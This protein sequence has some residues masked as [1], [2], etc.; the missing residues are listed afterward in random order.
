MV[1]AVGGAT[2]FPLAITLLFAEFPVHQ[3]GL[4]AGMLGI[5]SLMAPAIGPTLGGYLVTYATWR[6]IFFINV[7]L[8][9]VGMILALRLLRSNPSEKRARFDLPG[10]ALAAT[11]LTA[12]LYSLSMPASLDGTRQ[13]YLRH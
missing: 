12:V 1:Q 3:R 13:W 9:M 11:G 8:G 7:P 6:L 2:L 5:S 4:A 10:F